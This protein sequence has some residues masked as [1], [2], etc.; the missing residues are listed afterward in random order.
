M[1][2]QQ[3]SD[4][5][6][7][8][9]AICAKFGVPWIPSRVAA[10]CAEH[11]CENREQ[12]ADAIR[13]HAKKGKNFGKYTITQL[14]ELAGLP[15]FPHVDQREA[16]RKQKEKVEALIFDLRE[17]RSDLFVLARAMAQEL[18]QVKQHCSNTLRVNGYLAKFAHVVGQAE[19][20]EWILKE[21]EE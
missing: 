2:G 18:N 15:P 19:R 9:Q 3:M 6:Q 17:T 12:L 16:L 13:K 1:G 8:R 7:Q 14:R 20:Q 11:K 4:R 10:F 21:D 5:E